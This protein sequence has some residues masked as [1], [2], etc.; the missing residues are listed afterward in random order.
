MNHVSI[1]IKQ[2]TAVGFRFSREIYHPPILARIA[3]TYILP[4]AEYCSS[5]WS[6]NRIMA[7]REIEKSLHSL[8]RAVLQAPRHTNHPLY[9]G[10]QER[11]RK[12]NLFSLGERRT[13]A[14]IVTGIKLFKG[15]IDS[16]LGDLLRNHRSVVRTRHPNLFYFHNNELHPRSPLARIVSE[17]NNYRRHFKLDEATITS[18]SKLKKHI[19]TNINRQN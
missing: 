13:I 12:L 15:E 3:T 4:V 9:I 2:M 19:K 18:K 16:E 11:L 8:T 14:S 5:V 10:Y 7:E 1:K 6:Q 17:C